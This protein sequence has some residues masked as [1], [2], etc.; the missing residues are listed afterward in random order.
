MSYDET[1]SERLS[2]GFISDTPTGKAQIRNAKLWS[3]FREFRNFKN[4]DPENFDLQGLQEQEHD[5]AITPGE[6]EQYHKAYSEIQF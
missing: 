1:I 4:G 6:W 2:A 5:L 3:F